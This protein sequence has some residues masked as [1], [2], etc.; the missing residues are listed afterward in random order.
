MIS[1]T[2]AY[3]EAVE[4]GQELP[5]LAPPSAPAGPEASGDLSSR[6]RE[7]AARLTPAREAHEAVEAPASDVIRVPVLVA[8]AD[9][10]G[11][12]A[13]PP[14]AA[15]RAWL[16]LD[17]RLLA[18]DDAPLVFAYEVVPGMMRHL[19]GIAAPGDLIVFRRGPRAASDLVSAFRTRAGIV[20][21]RVLAKNRSLLL[22]P[23]EGERDFETIA[24][25]GERS[26]ADV[27][28]GAQVLLIRRAGEGSPS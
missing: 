20:L 3:I 6:L 9:P 13:S 16:L 4:S 7:V 23:G 21:A 18:P 12:G 24:V 26:L 22:L 11:P 5:P 25:Q 19:R 2:P 17:R 28:V 10:G 1:R 14:A 27:I 8:G 15:L